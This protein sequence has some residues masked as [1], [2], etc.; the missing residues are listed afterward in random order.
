MT[1]PRRNLPL[2]CLCSLALVSCGPD[3]ELNGFTVGSPYTGMYYIVTKEGNVVV[4]PNL[5]ELGI[6]DEY[7]YGYSIPYEY[8]DGF[9]TSGGYFVLDTNTGS[10]SEGLTGGQMRQLLYRKNGVSTN[11][12]QLKKLY[13]DN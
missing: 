6:S 12:I 8:P 13:N 4:Q 9:K 3:R 11:Q 1:D 7:W 2:L 10:V 5:R